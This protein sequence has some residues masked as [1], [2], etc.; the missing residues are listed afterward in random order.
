MILSAYK[1]HHNPKSGKKNEAVDPANF[2]RAV[3]EAFPD[4]ELPHKL[5]YSPKVVLE[6]NAGANNQMQGPLPWPESPNANHVTGPMADQQSTDQSAPEQSMA[7]TKGKAKGKKKKPRKKGRQANGRD[8][9]KERW[10]RD[11]VTA[12]VREEASKY[13]S[14]GVEPPTDMKWQ[15][16]VANEWATLQKQETKRV[17][18]KRQERRDLETQRHLKRQ[19]RAD[20]E[21]TEY[22][23]SENESVSG[24]S[25]DNGRESSLV[26]RLRNRPRKRL[27]ATGGV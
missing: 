14:T 12:F 16:R 20:R 21:Q 24:N 9:E 2:W 17:N 18:K 5:K 10:D 26:V 27:S 6:M 8:R 19:D 1:A 15:R 22:Q 13:L 3:R 23:P 4:D 11:R 25:L 7:Q